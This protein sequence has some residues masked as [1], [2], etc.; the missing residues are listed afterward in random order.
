MHSFI[1][2]L[3]LLLPF[4]RVA[5][6]PSKP[7][8]VFDAADAGEANEDDLR[9]L[10]HAAAN[11]PNTEIMKHLISLGADVNAR[12]AQ[13]RRPLHLAAA[14]DCGVEILA[15]LINHGAKVNAK[16]KDG[17]TPLDLAETEEKQSYLRAAGGRNTP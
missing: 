11:N 1:R 8:T 6:P 16:T 14:G 2:Q 15:L 10:L 4:F 13:G 17:E 3:I 9:T 7:Q 5:A 12:D